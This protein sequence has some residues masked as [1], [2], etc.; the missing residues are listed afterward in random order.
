MASLETF[1]QAICSNELTKKTAEEERRKKK[2]EE[3]RRKI[4]TITIGLQPDRL[5]P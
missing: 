5:D 2:K 1:C 3:E 4:P